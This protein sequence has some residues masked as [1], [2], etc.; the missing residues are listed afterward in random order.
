MGTGH[1][2]IRRY[3][4]GNQDRHGP[5]LFASRVKSSNVQAVAGVG[6]AICLMGLGGFCG[7]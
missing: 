3:R 5:N 6:S 4:G 2:A 1:T 7:A